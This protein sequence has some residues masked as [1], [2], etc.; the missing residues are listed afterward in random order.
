MAIQKIISANGIQQGYA[1]V[2]ADMLGN[3][4]TV[5]TDVAPTGLGAKSGYSDLDYRFQDDDDSIKHSIIAVDTSDSGVI[6][7]ITGQSI[8]VIDYAF[9]CTADA[10]VTFLSDTTPISSGMTFAEN[11]GISHDSSHVTL[12]TSPGEA[13]NIT[14][15]AGAVN[16]HISYRVG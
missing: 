6:T 12:Q 11:G 7:A 13:L 3:Y 4:D 16:G 15:S 1:V 10:T 5:N 14:T 8:E 2:G 9:L